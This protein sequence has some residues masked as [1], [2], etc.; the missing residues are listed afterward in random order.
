MQCD[1]NK[2][3]TSKSILAEGLPSTKPQVD[4]FC[5]IHIQIELPDGMSILDEEDVTVQVG[6][7]ELLQ[8]IDCSLLRMNVGE[9]AKHEIFNVCVP[10]NVQCQITDPYTASTPSKIVCVLNWLSKSIKM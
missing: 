2:N 9:Q 5:R 10:E 8:F 6:D 1:D 4:D 3:V 7:E